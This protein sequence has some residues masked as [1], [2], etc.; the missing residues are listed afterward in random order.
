MPRFEHERVA[1]GLREAIR[2]LCKSSLTYSTEL[3]IEGLL[4]ITLDNNEVFLVNIKEVVQGLEV[5]GN[6]RNNING[7]PMPKRFLT[8]HKNSTNIWHQPGEK[9]KLAEPA[10]ASRPESAPCYTR[11][12]IDCESELI[13]DLAEMKS[14]RSFSCHSSPTH[15]SI[16]YSNKDIDSNTTRSLFNN[17]QSATESQPCSPLPAAQPD[18]PISPAVPSDTLSNLPFQRSQKYVNDIIN[19]HWL[20]ESTS[21]SNSSCGSINSN[22]KSIVKQELNS[23]VITSHGDVPLNLS[24]S[25]SSRRK[26][27]VPERRR[28]ISDDAVADITNELQETHNSDNDSIIV[29]KPEPV[30]DIESD[31]TAMSPHSLSA[32]RSDTSRSSPTSFTSNTAYSSVPFLPYDAPV[33]PGHNGRFSSLGPQASLDLNDAAMLNSLQVSEVTNIQKGL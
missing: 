33:F 7:E 6:A 31:T 24:G 19:N 16:T 10:I 11:D 14:D 25:S 21:N 2:F 18:I 20:Q 22:T 3:S 26:S 8:S 13:V 17:C 28:N 12:D 15:P 4:G 9:R 30:D 5:N 32:V 23:H 27:S 1:I 29:V